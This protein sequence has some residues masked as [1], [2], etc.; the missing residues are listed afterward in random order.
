MT[1]LPHLAARLY[2]APLLIA[3]PKLEAILAALGPRLA[4]LAAAPSMEAWP[5]PAPQALES[6]IAILPILGTLVHRSA[7]LEAA[8][9]LMSYAEIVDEAE[10]LFARSDVRAVLMEID[11]S[12]GEAG[13]AFAA[14]RQLRELADASGKP[15][16]AIASE[17]ALSAAYALAAAADRVWVSDTGEAGSVGVVAVHVDQSAADAQA[18][19]AYTFIHAGAK[20]IDGHPHAPLS[21][22]ARA[23]LAADVEAL[24][25]RF[26]EWVA[27]R[28]GLTTA[29]VRGQEA[30]VYR[31]KAAL[32]AGLA[33]AVGSLREAIAALEAFLSP[34]HA[35]LRR[36]T[37]GGLA[38]SH[39][40]PAAASAAAETPI[41]FNEPRLA[42]RMAAEQA[43][44]VEQM[45]QI[46]E[47][48]E[49][50]KALGVA[51]DAVAAIREGLAPDALRARVLEEAARCD[52]A[53]DIVTVAPAAG[54]S[55]ESTL[56]ALAKQMAKKGA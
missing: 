2:G 10:A 55:S 6:G 37:S 33:D 27:A 36:P 7:Y 53:A 16:W 41:D 20:K 43:R 42:E 9:G 21:E 44:L 15:L 26:V 8:S 22:S 54:V 23:D 30:A 48:A 5:K 47:I 19:L 3:R 12:G 17:S 1:D 24:Y 40:E 50:A 35:A 28:R 29:A 25:A 52:A 56:V 11:S 46:V 51:I 38:M 32:A 13:G 4:G 45:A 14:A 39:A 31:G 18:G 49:Q 34:T